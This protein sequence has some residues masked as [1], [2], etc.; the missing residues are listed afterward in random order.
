[1]KR[2]MSVDLHLTSNGM[3]QLTPDGGR[4]VLY[5]EKTG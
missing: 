4:S 5:I 3:R 1:M 2:H